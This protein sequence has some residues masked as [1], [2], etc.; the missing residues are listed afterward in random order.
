MN[1]RIPLGI[2]VGFGGLL[3][4]AA[5]SVPTP[6]SAAELLINNYLPPKHP[7]QTV[8][9]VPWMK[10]V[11]AATN[12][13][14]NVKLSAAAVGP[15]PK[16][17]QTVSK[18][19]ADVVLLANLFQPKRLELPKLAE[20]PLF[21]PSSLKTSIALTATQ[22]K[23]FNKANEYKGA[24][25]VGSFVLTPTIIHSAKGPLTSVSH[26]KGLK[27]RASPGANAK[28]IA[29]LGAV[30]VPSGP[31]KIF[32]IVSKGIV[33][34][35]SVPAHALRAFRIMPYINASTIVPG[36]LINVSFS[37]LINGKKWD[38]LT[39]EQQ[40]KV[41]SVSGMHIAKRMDRV[42]AIAASALKAL[43]EKGG[44][45]VQADES[46]MKIVRQFAEDQKAA[47]LKTAD[48]RGIDGKAAL[49]FFQS[50]IK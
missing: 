10:D 41:S 29:A 20:F 33:D 40:E 6:A 11:I 26:F 19:L 47:W 24:H 31:N 32:S 5:V 3:A 44:K 12:G 45:I 8:V 27:V 15:A 4:T 38:G 46:V 17:W 18:G 34:G 39:K 42:D 2:T 35:A 43:E 30:P 21:S 1:I 49:D 16:N 23:Y 14:V 25:L 7:F 22:E 36:G 28:I 13:S 37:L 50:Q 9:T 48:A